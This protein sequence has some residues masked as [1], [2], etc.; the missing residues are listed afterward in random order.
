MPVKIDYGKVTMPKGKAS[1]EEVKRY[2]MATY[3]KGAM[4]NFE[5]YYHKWCEARDRL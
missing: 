4:T 2:F 3:N 1:K 5:G